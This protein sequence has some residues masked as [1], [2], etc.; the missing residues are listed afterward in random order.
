MLTTGIFRN[1]WWMIF[2][3]VLGLMVNTGVITVFT[4]AVFLKP[5]TETL[6][7]PRAT[8]GAALIVGSLCSMVA[9][10]LFGKAI[11]Y[12]GLRVV[13]LPMICG[14]A[15]ATAAMSLLR[16]P[17]AVLALLFALHGILGSGQSPVAYSKAIAAWFDK[18]RGLALG[19]AIAGVGLGVAV[20][21]Q[22]ASHLI[23]SFGWRAAYVGLGIAIIVFALIPAA[24]F[25]REPPTRPERAQD[26]DGAVSPGVALSE[27][28]GAWRFWAMAVAFFLV[29]VAVNGTLTQVVA[30]LTDRGVPLRLAVGA[31]SAAGLA[32]TAGRIISGLCLDRIH[33]PYVATFFFVAAIAGIALLASAAGGAVSLV[34]TILC[35]LGIGA[36]VDLMAF[37]VS[38]YF[39]L[40]AFGAIYGAMFAL[41]SLGNGVGPFLMGYS[42]DHAH[43]YVPMML[44]FEVA[45]ALACV[46]LLTLGPYRFAAKLRDPAPVR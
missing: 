18:N 36:E 1:R 30:L 38:R 7:I 37:F 41:F 31:L 29:V 2:G 12:F 44:V 9:T 35:G 13:H 43:S 15:L 17:F 32:L 4:F 19:I 23:V 11:D 3:S 5:I 34:G 25:V 22:I 27:A 14:F 42:Y 20:V 40:R 33:G 10:P 16:M 46:L 24:L 8:I 28:M 39:G 26:G 45:L 21:P 6:G